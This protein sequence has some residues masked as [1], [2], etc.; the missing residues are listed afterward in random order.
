MNC[1]EVRRWLSPYL[2]SELGKTKTFE[3]SEHLR[4]C[5]VCATRFER[6]RRVDASMVEQLSS[7]V[8]GMDF[9]AMLRE[10]AKPKRSLVRS[11]GLGAMGMAACLALIAWIA[12]GSSP[13]RSSAVGDWIASEFVSVAPD[14]KAFVRVSGDSVD[15]LGKVKS[16]LG[17]S[18]VMK[19]IAE[20]FPGHAVEVVSVAERGTGGALHYVEVR[21]NCC[22]EPV[23][24][25]FA[26]RNEMRRL[27]VL[28]EGVETGSIRRHDSSGLNLAMWA[29]DE[30]VLVAAS[31]HSVAN[32]VP[33]FSLDA[34]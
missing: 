16:T 21:L 29:T 28:P 1:R 20:A 23:L 10:A 3:V 12:V 26:A 11:W 34:A 17:V 7:N 15:L 5:E 18:L 4:Q 31:H 2:D 24:L 27:G 19:S 33:A 8:S 30:L 22:G 6:E 13:G 25:A 32:I 9:G 14:A